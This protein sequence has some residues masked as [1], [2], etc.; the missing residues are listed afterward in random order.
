[1]K[2]SAEKFKVFE[3]ST[4]KAGESSKHFYKRIINLNK[5]KWVVI[6]ETSSDNESDSSKSEESSVLSSDENSFPEMNDDNF[7]PFSK[8]NLKLKVGKIEISDQFFPSKE[9]F[10]AETTFNGKCYIFLGKW[11][12]GR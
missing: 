6:S 9:E 5:Q 4:F 7:P 12:M 1:M 10:D 8:E 3:N 11:P 2:Q